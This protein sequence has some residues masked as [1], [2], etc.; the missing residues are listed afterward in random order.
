MAVIW[1]R[2]SYTKEE[3]VEAWNSSLSIA[4]VAKKV[5]RN[6]NGSGYLTLKTAANELGLSYEHMTGQG[7]NGGER[8]RTPR[9]HRPLEEIL[10]EKSP[11][12]SSSSLKARLYKEGLLDKKCY[13]CGIT[14]WQG[15][16]A[17]LAIDH[18]NGIRDDN[19]IENL[20]ILCYNC[21]GQTETF[22][23]KNQKR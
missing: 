6:V 22:A 1:S 14:E 4:E 12:L 21:H 5:G 17:P 7:W 23:G 18:V 16:P 19:R 3:F 13:F 9:P 11:H 15:K 20:R 8:Y 10:V 2:R